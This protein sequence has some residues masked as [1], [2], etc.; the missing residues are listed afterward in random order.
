M[1]VP[2]QSRGPTPTPS[3]VAELVRSYLDANYRW[4]HKDD[5]H[6]V[7]IG[8]PVPALEMLHP[9]TDGFGLLSAWNPHS[10]ERSDVE[11]RREDAALHQLLVDANHTFRPAFAS[12][13]NRSWREPGWVVIDLPLEE[14]DLLS[15]Q[16]GQLGTL[17]WTQGCPVRLR[18]DAPRP[19]AFDGD[20]HIDW[21]QRAPTR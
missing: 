17:W 20:R 8:L 18:I 14:F 2:G 10:V 12:A 9:D 15:R 5:W 1:N 16:F 3:H 4:K 13:H 6:D 21:L 11:N 7:Q 19:E